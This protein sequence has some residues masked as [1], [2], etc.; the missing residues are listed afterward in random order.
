MFFF[1]LLARRQYSE[2]VYRDAEGLRGPFVKN[3]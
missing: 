2:K 1:P 3:G